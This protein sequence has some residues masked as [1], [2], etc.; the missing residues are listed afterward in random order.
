MILHLLMKSLI[1]IIWFGMI[2]RLLNYQLYLNIIYCT[3]PPHAEVTKLLCPHHEGAG[4]PHPINGGAWFMVSDS[5]GG[6]HGR[7]EL[8][9]LRRG[10][11]GGVSVCSVRKGPREGGKGW[12]EGWVRGDREWGVR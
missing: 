12:R 4:S 3:Q 7:A 2:M 6:Y 9:L 8:S 11:P 10:G 1:L 5:V